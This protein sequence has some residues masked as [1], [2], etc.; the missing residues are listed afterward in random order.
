MLQQLPPSVLAINILQSFGKVVFDTIFEFKIENNFASIT[1]SGFKQH[2]PC[3]NQL[4][5]ITHS[6]FNNS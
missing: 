4:I 1:Q 2:D 3:F 5:S 6:V